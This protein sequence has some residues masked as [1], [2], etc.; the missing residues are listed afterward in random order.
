MRK[1]STLLVESTQSGL[2]FKLLAS[3]LSFLVSTGEFDKIP[4]PGLVSG[5]AGFLSRLCDWNASSLKIGSDF[6]ASTC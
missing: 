6:C 4:A 2:G 1:L 3:A 5:C